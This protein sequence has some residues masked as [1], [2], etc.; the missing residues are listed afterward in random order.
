MHCHDA[1]DDVQELMGA[2]A[3]N[4]K[5]VAYTITKPSNRPARACSYA[6]GQ[7]SLQGLKCAPGHNAQHTQWPAYPSVWQLHIHNYTPTLSRHLQVCKQP[8]LQCVS[9]AGSI[10]HSYSL[11]P[12]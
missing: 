11:L 7:P 4:S 5:M 12:W 10:I 2:Q 1:Q 9:P 3:S 8:R 6:Q